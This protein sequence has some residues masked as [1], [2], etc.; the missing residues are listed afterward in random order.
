MATKTAWLQMRTAAI[1]EEKKNQQQ[2]TQIIKIKMEIRH[3]NGCG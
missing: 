2:H 3:G 1:Q